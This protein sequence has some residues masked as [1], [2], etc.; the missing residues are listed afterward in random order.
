MIVA[1]V[2]V[3]AIV[4]LSFGISVITAYGFGAGHGETLSEYFLRYLDYL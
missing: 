3:A 1:A 4:T 2:L